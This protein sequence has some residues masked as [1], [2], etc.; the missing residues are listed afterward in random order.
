M[1][2]DGAECGNDK[3]SLLSIKKI[4]FNILYNRY[5]LNQLVIIKLQFWKWLVDAIQQIAIREEFAI[6]LEI[7]I[8]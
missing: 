1:V 3:V 4:F 5:A 6:M 2:P 7:V 8:V